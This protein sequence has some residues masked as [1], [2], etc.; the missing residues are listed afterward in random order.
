ME[1]EQ[2]TSNLKKELAEKGKEYNLEIQPNADKVE[3]LLKAFIAKK[4]RLNTDLNYCPC[5]VGEIPDNICPCKF[6]REGGKEFC[7]CR[8]FRE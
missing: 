8:L 5:R 6:T 4:K 2:E 3:S 1:P 7:T